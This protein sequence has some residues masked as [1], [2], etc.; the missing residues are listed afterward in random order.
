MRWGMLAKQ[1]F[2]ALLIAAASGDAVAANQL[3]PN[4]LLITL[5]DVCPRFGCYGDRL[6]HTPTF[7]RLAEQGIRFDNAYSVAGVC[8]PSRSAILSGRWPV[9][10]GSHHMRSGVALPDQFRCTTAF[11]RDAGYYCFNAGKTDYNFKAPADSWDVSKKGASWRQCPDEQP[12]FG[13]YNYVETHQGP[14]QNAAIAARQRKRIDPEIVV[15]PSD[16]TV[17]PYYP[18]TPAVRQQLANVYNNI[19][20]ADMLVGRLLQKLADDGLTDSTIVILY[21]DHGDGIPRV[22]GH[23]FRDSLRVPFLISIPKRFRSGGHDVGVANSELVSLLDLGPTALSLAGVDPPEGFDGRAVLGSYKASPP[24]YLCAHR[25]RVNSAY[26]F[27]RAVFDERWHYLRNFRPD[28]EPH[29]P[30]RGHIQ[31]PAAVE[32]H[33]LH[34][35]GDFVGRG[36]DWLSRTGVAEALYDTATDPHCL[37]NL[38]TEPAHAD[39]VAEFRSRLRDWQIT[40]R[41]LGFLPESLMIAEA[42]QH[43]CPA[44]IYTSDI[45]VGRLH[46]LAISTNQSALIASLG[47]NDAATRYWAALGIGRLE[48]VSAESLA[49]VSVL[50]QDSEPAV[51]RAAAWALHQH[52]KSSAASIEV[53]LTSLKRGTY[54]DRLDAIQIARLIGPPA[55]DLVPE[56][57]RWVEK[58][59]NNYYSG[60][61]PSAATFALESIQ[62][63]E[64]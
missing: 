40:H 19:A 46:D 61:L 23:V 54:A 62:G 2:C 35:S 16:V 7:D 49:R 28:F 34:A 57:T 56:L 60:Y 26:N 31:A 63:G 47:S 59:P 10:L 1:I 32:A 15:E 58:K 20:L 8:A 21:G 53:L 51:A 12:F 41:D 48:D 50:L 14:S 24:R 45:E 9:T 13:V 36:T 30:V 64:R 27:E 5:E 25:D 38:I 4:F 6:A 42:R 39:R 33:R 11:L 3:R 55:A 44:A 29:P 22:K 18:D 37:D 52:G 43:D 17:P